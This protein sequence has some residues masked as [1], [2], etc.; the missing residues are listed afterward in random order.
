MGFGRM[1]TRAEFLAAR[2]GRRLNGPLFFIEAL[3][4]KDEN[5][6]R[7]GLTVTRKVGNAV[8]R[9]RIRRR[10]REAVR[11]ECGNDMA[12]G[13]DYVVVARR[14]LLGVPFATLKHELSRRFARTRRDRPAPADTSRAPTGE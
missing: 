14:D 6:A 2:K 10:L 1:K 9:N 12:S 13:F 4:R 8:E 11:L 3:D 5:E 7:L